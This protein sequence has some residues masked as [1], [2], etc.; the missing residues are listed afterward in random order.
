MHDR[1]RQN[2]QAGAV[3]FDA[4]PK[5]DE[6]RSG[7]H[8]L[9]PPLHWRGQPPP[10]PVSQRS[11]SPRDELTSAPAPGSPGEPAEERGRNVEER[12]AFPSS[13]TTGRALPT[14]GAKE[15]NF[16]PSARSAGRGPFHSTSSLLNLSSRATAGRPHFLYR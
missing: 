1:V 8:G 7:P 11:A 14:G 13:K 4:S 12:I 16:S 10:S 9:F 15:L 3:G 6:Q 2:L 5:P